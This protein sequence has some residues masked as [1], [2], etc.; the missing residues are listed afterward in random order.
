LNA[1]AEAHKATGVESPTHSTR[2]RNTMKGIRRT[3]GQLQ[4]RSH[5]LSQMTSKRWWRVWMRG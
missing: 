2:V 5:L 4:H 3:L 1:I